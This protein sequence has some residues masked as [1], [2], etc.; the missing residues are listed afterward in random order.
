MLFKV[1]KS[2]GGVS[3][4]MLMEAALRIKNLVECGY[5]WGMNVLR[6]GRLS[7]ELLT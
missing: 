5:D 7:L 2:S 6:E 1:D 4:L 3:I